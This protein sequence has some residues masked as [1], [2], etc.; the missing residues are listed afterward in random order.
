MWY[1]IQVRTRHEGEIIE[2]CKEK[3]LLPGEE[4]FTI[5][6][7]RIFHK[8]E[9]RFIREYV[10][11]PGY[12]FYETEQDTDSLRLRLKNIKQMTKLLHTGEEFIPLYPEEEQLLRQLSGPE[13]KIGFSNGIKDGDLVLIKEGPLVGQEGRIRWIDRHN[14]MAGIEVKLLGRKISIKLGL[15]LISKPVL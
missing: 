9:E 12:V 13:H 2:E 4:V 3:V 10:V 11:F 5:L 15:A 7:E 14:R 6:G 8:N 1:V